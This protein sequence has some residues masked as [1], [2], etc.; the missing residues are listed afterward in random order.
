MQLSR[1]CSI[2]INGNG[3]F[4]V[5]STEKLEAGQSEATS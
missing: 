1:Y 2:V 4:Y 3:V 5:V